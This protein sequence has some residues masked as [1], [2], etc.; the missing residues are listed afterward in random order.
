MSLSRIDGGGIGGGGVGGFSGGGKETLIVLVVALVVGVSIYL[1]FSARYFVNE[2]RDLKCIISTVDGNR[3][4]VRDQR[5]IQDAA[6]LLARIADK[7]SALVAFC[8]ETYPDDDRVQRLVQNFDPERIM[9]T[10][11]TSEHTAYS[12]NKGEKIAFCLHV[13]NDEVSPLI[14]EDTLMF[15]AIHELA[16]VAS[17]GVGHKTEF[18]DNFKFLL[19]SAKTAGIHQPVDYGATPHKYCG[20]QIKD[21]PYYDI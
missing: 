11:P 13:E 1:Y 2:D 21:N 4:C 10:L 9:E 3:Y 15:V 18:W 5:R 20:V 6:D 8:A 14:D 19:E 12:E 16:H 17:V 7:C